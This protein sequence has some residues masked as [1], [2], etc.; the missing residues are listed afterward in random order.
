MNDAAVTVQY[1]GDWPQMPAEQLWVDWARVV[2]AEHRPDG[3]LTLRLVGR[4]EGRDLNQRYRGRDC[5]TNVLSFPME[6]PAGL[7]AEVP[8][9]ELGDLVICMPVVRQEAE[10]QGKPLVSHCAHLVIHGCLHLLGFDHE[11]SAEAER[12]E[13]EEVRLLAGLGISDPYAVD[14]QAA[15]Q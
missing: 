6:R 9:T 2:L 15:D 7:P 13:A 11:A 5:A 14:D 4:A 3:L 8:M 1:A 12:M 10:A